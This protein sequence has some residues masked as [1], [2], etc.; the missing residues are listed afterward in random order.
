MLY[1]FGGTAFYNNTDNYY[2]DLCIYD[3]D[4]DLWTKTEILLIYPST[5]QG[6]SAVYSNYLYYFFG[7][8]FT[9]NIAVSSSSILRMNLSS[10]ILSWEILS[11]NGCDLVELQRTSF[12]FWLDSDTFYIL[13]GTLSNGIGNSLISIALDNLIENLSCKVVFPNQL[14]PQRRHGSSLVYVTGGFLMFGGIDQTKL[15]NDLWFY[16]IQTTYWEFIDASG[17]R[18]APRF[19]HTTA[20]QGNYMVVFGGVTYN[21]E[22]LQDFYYYDVLEQ[23]WFIIETPVNSSMPQ[24]LI[25]SCI[26]I[27]LPFV[28]LIGGKEQYQITLNLWMFNINTFTFTQIFKYKPNPVYPGIF[29]HSCSG[30]LVGK[31]FLIYTYLGSRNIVDEPFCGI[32]RFNLSAKIVTPEIVLRNTLDMPCRTDAAFADLGDGLVLF[33]GGQ[34]FKENSFTDIWAMN[35]T[36][37][38]TYMIGTLPEGAFATAAS[39]INATL[40]IF[41]GLTSNGISVDS[42]SSDYFSKFWFGKNTAISNNI[43]CGAGMYNNQGNCVFCPAGTYSSPTSQGECM[44]CPN[45]TSNILTGATSITQCIPCSYGY[46][47]IDSSKICKPCQKDSIC[48]IGTGTNPITSSYQDYLYDLTQEN[49]QPDEYS[50]KNIY[51]K[52]LILI[53]VFSTI[54]FLFIIIFIFSLKARIFFSYY[55]IYKNLH[56]EQHSTEEGFEIPKEILNRPSKLGGFCSTITIIALLFIGIN[57]LL[58]YIL[59]NMTED[60]SVIPIGSLIQEYDFENIDF[61]LEIVTSSYRGQC[62]KQYVLYN[63]S[64]NL[65]ISSIQVKNDDVFCKIICSFTAQELISN[66]ES[67]TFSFNEILSYASDA[68]AKL[69]T[70]S[71]IGSEKSIA[72]Q[73]ITSTTGTVFRGSSPIVFSFALLPSYYESRNVLDEENSKVGYRIS[74]SLIPIKGTETGISNIP[75]TNGFSI[76]ILFVRNDIGVT[77]YRYPSVE[78]VDFIIKFLNDFPGTIVLIGFLMWFFEYFK[79]VIQGKTSGRLRLVRKQIKEEQE[80]RRARKGVRMSRSNQILLDP[81]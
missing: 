78:L 73:N 37:N 43:N 7:W 68:Y 77:T 32:Y 71:S 41:S 67:I 1:L 9:N 19:R 56:F 42:P 24:P 50:P 69:S 58:S 17:Q 27:D 29:K 53:I 70:K 66:G 40:F 39:Y 16:N 80:E 34:R 8:N 30:E 28:Y 55:D 12:G 23:V 18:P 38:A 62:E 79:N 63:Q 2:S 52:K 72:V 26:V 46:Y 31:D 75:I 45:G 61:E 35:I 21:N 76:K 20:S 49:S 44:I 54:A 11:S 36:N 15:F 13:G 74:E 65:E 14:S 22:Y 25:S 60:I 3:F 10:S 4:T 57:T 6:G 81:N 59:T 33:A 51:N 64:E 47:S 5:T 48:F